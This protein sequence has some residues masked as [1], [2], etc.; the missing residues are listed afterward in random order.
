MIQ[1]IQHVRH[2][3]RCLRLAL[4][5]AAVGALCPTAAAVN[6]VDGGSSPAYRFLDITQ[7]SR[8]CGLGGVNV[9]DVTTDISVV[10]QNP[11]LL[12]PEYGRQIGIDYMKYIGG[13]NFAGAQF[14]TPAGEHGAWGLGLRYFGYGS[15]DAT[16]ISGVV[17]GSFA[18]K[19]ILLTGTW[20]RD[21]KG[22]WRGGAAVKGIYSSYADY[23]A[24]ALAVDLG[25]NYYDPERDLSFGA[26]LVNLGGQIKRFDTA[27]DRLPV[28]LRLGW[29]KSFGTFPV[30]FSV[31]AWNLTKWHL[32][33]WRNETDA[34]GMQV[35]ELTESFGS[36]LFRHLVFGAAFMPSDRFNIT[37]G[38]NYKTRTDMSTYAR[39]FFSGVSVGAS[40]TLPSIGIG[41]AYT[42]PHTG[43]SVLLVNFSLAM[44]AL[45]G[46]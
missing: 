9:S 28:D 12:G 8:V 43:A 25:V 24:L 22:C 11:A 46:E 41:L 2:A 1:P 39:S 33:Y 16:D 21:I 20:S 7:S 35:A 6:P 44:D 10:A 42:Q 32:P 29:S 34:S 17:T 38:Y 3:A 27:Y 14:C 40:L 23:S 30:R 4:W 18:P 5:G 31:T 13:S 15:M 36:N 26:A 45:T 19:D 37:L